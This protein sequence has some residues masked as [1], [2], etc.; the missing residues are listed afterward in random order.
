MGPLFPLLAVALVT[1]SADMQA[2]HLLALV[3][4]VL[5]YQH[6]HQFKVQHLVMLVA[7]PT[8]QMPTV[9]V[10][11]EEPV[12]LVVLELHPLAV[13]VAS[14]PLKPRC[15]PARCCGGARAWLRPLPG[16]RMPSRP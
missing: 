15:A 2:V 10:V 4:L 13:P 3:V 1:A 9:Q 11:A 7:F 12:Q 8:H 5:A 6:L 14:A 16:W